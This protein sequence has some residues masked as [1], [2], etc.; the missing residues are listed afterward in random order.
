MRMVLFSGNGLDPAQYRKRRDR[1]MIKPINPDHQPGDM[2]ITRHDR[3]AEPGYLC[4]KCKAF[5]H[6]TEHSEERRADNGIL[7]AKCWR[8]Q[9]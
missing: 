9:E 7:C 8:E 3:C 4:S 5:I 2:S 6:H 1:P